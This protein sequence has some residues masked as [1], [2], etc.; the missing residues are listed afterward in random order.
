MRVLGFLIIL[1]F[2][3]NSTKSEDYFSSVNALSKLLSTEEVLVNSLEKYLE[4]Q[5]KKIAK[6]ER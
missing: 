4:E 6:L 2:L 5:Y 1:M 3:M